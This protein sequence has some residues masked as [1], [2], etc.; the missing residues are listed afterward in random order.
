MR[1]MSFLPVPF[2]TSSRWTKETNS[3]WKKLWWNRM[4]W[5]ND[6]DTVDDLEIRRSPVD[7]VN[8]PCKY[9][10]NSI[11]HFWDQVSVYLWFDLHP[12]EKTC[13]SIHIF[14]ECLSYPIQVAKTLPGSPGK[15]PLYSLGRGH[16]MKTKPKQ[17]T[18]LRGKSL[19]TTIDLHQVLGA[20]QKWQKTSENNRLENLK[21]INGWSMFSRGLFSASKC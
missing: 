5:Y 7:M 19:K 13:Q 15:T 4:G 1:E 12:D 18:I 21:K 14:P 20:P 17:C 2:T 6:T 11:T 8:I 16:Y 10:I 9:S 3:C